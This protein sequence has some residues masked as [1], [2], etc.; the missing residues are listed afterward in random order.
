MSSS[1]DHVTSDNP[2]E[3]SRVLGDNS[4]SANPYVS[5]YDFDL[6]GNWRVI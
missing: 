4:I 5:P 2:F 1:E 3:V 6:E